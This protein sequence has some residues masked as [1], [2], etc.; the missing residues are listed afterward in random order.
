MEMVMDMAV[1]DLEMMEIR[2]E[3]IM[4]IEMVEMM[5]TMDKIMM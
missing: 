1:T 2:M 4:L 3:T 5:D